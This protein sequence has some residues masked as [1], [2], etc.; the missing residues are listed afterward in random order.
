MLVKNEGMN[1]EEQCYQLINHHTC[2]T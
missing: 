1:D 2:A